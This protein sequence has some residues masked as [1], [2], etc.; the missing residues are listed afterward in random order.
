[1]HYLLII[2]V[3]VGF[4][5]IVFG[6]YYPLET[7]DLRDGCLDYIEPGKNNIV[8]D[9]DRNI[10]RKKDFKYLLFPIQI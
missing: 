7:D 4:F 1:M 3:S 2:L 6:T 10:D 9:P 8:G 5:S